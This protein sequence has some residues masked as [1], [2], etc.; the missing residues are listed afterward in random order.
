MGMQK[1]IPYQ[2]A[3]ALKNYV[4]SGKSLIIVGNSGHR[5]AENPDAFGWKAIFGSIVP[6]DCIENI[7]QISPCVNPTPITGMF[8]NTMISNKFEGI[9]EIP[10]LTDRQSG[11]PG[12]NLTIYPV[13]HNGE[14]WMYIKDI[15]T[16]KQYSGIV[17]NKSMLG[18]KVVYFSFEEWGLI[19]NVIHRVFE[20]VQ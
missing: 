1:A 2:L 9:D 10:S 20:Y 18:G 19:P 12:L 16:Q 3:E 15:R 5:E 6:V 17:V 7:D 14:E 11:K 4:A 13:N 8:R